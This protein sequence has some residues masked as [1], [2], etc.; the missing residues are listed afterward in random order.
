MPRGLVTSG[1]LDSRCPVVCVQE[2][3]K[4]VMKNGIISSC[5]NLLDF[6][7]LAV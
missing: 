2:A 6:S 5:R 3:L 1:V 4:G 7:N